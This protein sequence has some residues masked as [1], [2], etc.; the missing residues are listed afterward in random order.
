MDLNTVAKE[1]MAL[2]LIDD[3][4]N[5]DEKAFS[6][7]YNMYAVALLNYGMCLTSDKEMVRDCVHDVFVKLLVKCKTSKISKVSSYLFISLRNR[8]TDEF[9]RGSFSTD[10]PINDNKMRRSDDSAE[11]LFIRQ[12]D[13]SI[14]HADVSKLF[15]ELTPRQRKAFNLYFIEQK[16]YDEICHILQMNYP[17]VRNLV[18]RGM[19]KLRSSETFRQMKLT[20]ARPF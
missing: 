2:R 5:G 6:S 16:K 3:Y 1:E 10:T 9:R 12:E 18:H 8:L 17:C 4:R 7:L 20:G 14:L 19:M 13:D 11:D 15:A